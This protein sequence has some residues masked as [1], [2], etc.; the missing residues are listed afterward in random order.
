MNQ[1]D[2]PLAKD[3]L[4]SALKQDPNNPEVHSARAMLF[5][6]MG[7][8]AK[9]DDGIPH[10]LAPRAERSG[11]DQQLRGLPVPERSHR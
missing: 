11:R 9:A 3:K 2:L 10:R 1:G 7:Q 5:E 4:D 8:P 6:R